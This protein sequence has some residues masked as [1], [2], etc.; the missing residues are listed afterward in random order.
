MAVE[1]QYRYA[2]HAM[3]DSNERAARR[4]FAQLDRSNAR[5][6]DERG[7]DVAAMVDRDVN[8]KGPEPSGHDRNRTK[9]VR[10]QRG[11]APVDAA[12]M[13]VITYLE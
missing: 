8:D 5:W 3:T 4:H 7:G 11:S 10:F 1:R 9:T 12:G 2:I 13:I 6:L